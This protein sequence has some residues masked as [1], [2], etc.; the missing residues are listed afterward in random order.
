MKWRIFSQRRL[1]WRGI[2]IENQWRHQWLMAIMA[3][4]GIGSVKPKSGKH[5]LNR[6][7][8]GGN[9]VAAMAI[10]SSINGVYGIGNGGGY[11]RQNRR[12]A[13]SA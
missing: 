6:R 3:A 11:R 8:G 13:T 5:Q 7:G 10:I 2:S 1:S 12:T 9:G 4:A